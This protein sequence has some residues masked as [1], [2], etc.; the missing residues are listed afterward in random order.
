MFA[1]REWAF[2]RTEWKQSRREL[3]LSRREWIFPW[4]KLKLRGRECICEQR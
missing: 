1:W 4:S 2:T 3:K